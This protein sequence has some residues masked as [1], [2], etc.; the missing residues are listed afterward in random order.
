MK[1]RGL[2]A[3]QL[4]EQ[5]LRVP[6][7]G[8]RTLGPLTLHAEQAR[9]ID[10]WDAVDADGRPIYDELFCYWQKKTGKST[11]TGG[12]VLHELIAGRESDREILLVSSDLDQSKDIT[13]ASVVRFVD[14]HPWLRQHVTCG[15]TEVRFKETLIDPQTGGRHIEEHLIRAI[16][17]RDAKSL[18]GSNATLTT[19]DE[20]WTQSGYDVVEALG[21]SPA[22]QHP[23]VLY[24]SYAGLRS[25]QHAGNPLWDLHQRW[26][27]GDDP[28]LFVS[29]IGG[30][31]G[32]R[33]VPWLTEAFMEQERRRFEAVP[34]KFRRL[35][36]NE[37][38]S[39]DEGTFLTASEIADATD[40]ALPV[41][42]IRQLGM[43][44][45][46]GGDLGLTHDLTAIAL[47]HV[48]LAGRVVVDAVRSWQGTRATPV[49]LIA[50]EAVLADWARRF[51]AAIHL[52]QWQG[53]FLAQRLQASGVRVTTHTIETARLDN[54]ASLLKT[55]FKNRY[56]RIPGHPTL[57][58]QLETIEGEELARRDRVRFTS[59]PGGHDD[60]VMA[61]CLSVESF[62]RELRG[63]DNTM[64][65]AFESRTIGRQRMEDITSCRAWVMNPRSHGQCPLI[66]NGSANTGCAK[67]AAFAST[68]RAHQ[69]YLAGG[70]SYMSRLAFIDRHMVRSPY[71]ERMKFGLAMA[72]Y[73]F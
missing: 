55:L 40:A 18:H 27:R 35:Y 14:R 49:D 3:R 8:R 28:R 7:R 21:R 39:S 69:E 37:W 16:P 48:D 52:D 68:E 61:I 65:L 32:W 19:F 72:N 23:R 4:F 24:A 41:E 20:Y 50:V 53:A 11:T 56:V 70:G 59:G 2:T 58:E 25:S 1:T 57:I 54:Y 36:Q 26:K 64:Q 46:I 67:C 31:D 12:L 30:S 43:T 63:P 73:M 71:I 45:S 13:F 9:L 47:S 34:S 17:A 62:V 38:A 44:Y 29:Y 10:A 22:R 66:N 33:S 51:D 5:V 60:L 42:P 15:R 6:Q